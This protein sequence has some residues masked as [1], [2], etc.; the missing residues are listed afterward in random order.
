MQGVEILTSAQVATEWA[1]NW[2]TFWITFGMIFAVG[3]FIIIINFIDYGFDGGTLCFVCVTCALLGCMF[4]AL[5][6]T[7]CETPIAHETQY[8]ATISDEV[9]MSDFYEHYEVIEQD[10][11]IFTI[12]EKTDEIK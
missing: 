8:K 10:G 7:I 9:S 1:F 12:R 5:F 2:T 11:K 4:S 6:G 3:A